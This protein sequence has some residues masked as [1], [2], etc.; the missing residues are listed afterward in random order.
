MRYE[1]FDFETDSLGIESA[2]LKICNHYKFGFPSSSTG[3]QELVPN[4]TQHL[5]CSTDKGM[6]TCSIRTV[7]KND[8]LYHIYVNF[9]EF[10]PKK[11]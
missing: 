9:V 3:I 6:F 8:E 11:K 7:K 1:S 2:E 10:T 5:N 4:S